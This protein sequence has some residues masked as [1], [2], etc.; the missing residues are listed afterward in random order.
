MPAL[1]LA[2]LSKQL[3]P[4]ASPCGLCPQTWWSQS[5][6]A[7]ETGGSPGAGGRLVEAAWGPDCRSLLLAYEGSPQVGA[8]WGDDGLA[9]GDLSCNLRCGLSL[10]DD[11]LA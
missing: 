9:W 3:P 2:L 8:Q 5:W 6:A 1:Q 11:L 10:K 4:L 7:A